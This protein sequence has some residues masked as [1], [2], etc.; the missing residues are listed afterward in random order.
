MSC[1]VALHGYSCPILFPFQL[2]TVHKRSKLL[3]GQ[4]WAGSGALASVCPIRTFLVFLYIPI[5]I[6]NKLSCVATLFLLCGGF[7]LYAIVFN[8]TWTS[9][10][11]SSILGSA[12]VHTHLITCLAAASGMLCCLRPVVC[13]LLLVL[14][15]FDVAAEFQTVSAVFEI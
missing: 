9:R 1:L 5:S 6:M 4:R 3:V 10:V 11:L 8:K 12:S 2:R 7:K 14:H 15:S 13:S